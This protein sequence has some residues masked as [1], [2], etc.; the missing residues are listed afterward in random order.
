MNQDLGI[1]G[2]L[3][4]SRV[5]SHT[6]RKPVE[7]HQGQEDPQAARKPKTGKESIKGMPREALKSLKR[8]QN[9]GPGKDQE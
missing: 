8:S 3:A 5:L 4:T 2:L 6:Q 7:P 1:T 9:W